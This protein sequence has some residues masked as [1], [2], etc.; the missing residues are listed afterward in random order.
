MNRRLGYHYLITE[1]GERVHQVIVEYSHDGRLLA[2]HPFT[3]EEAFV[4]WVGGIL[5]LREKN[6]Q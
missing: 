2:W 3:Q 6:M 1:N 4:E 5:D